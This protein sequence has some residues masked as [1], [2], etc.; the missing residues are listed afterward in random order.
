MIVAEAGRW[1]AI[2]G[3]LG[4]GIAYVAAKGMRSLLFGLDPADPLTFAAGLGVV[5]L[6]TLAGAVAPAWRAVRISPLVAL[7]SD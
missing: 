6:V 5:V 4:V 1:T 3:V 7:R 2:G